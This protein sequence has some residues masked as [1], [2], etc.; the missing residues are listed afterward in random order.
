MKDPK[1]LVHDM[2]SEELRLVVPE[3]CPNCHGHPGK[4]TFCKKC[5]RKGV[6]R[7]DYG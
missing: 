4:K 1:R 3:D 6:I 7:V 5:K 2:I